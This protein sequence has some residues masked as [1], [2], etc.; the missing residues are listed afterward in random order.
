MKANQKTQRIAG[1]IGFLAQQS[2]WWYWLYAPVIFTLILAMH[3]INSLAK[4][5][6]TINRTKEKKNG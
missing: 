6:L 1:G 2:F 4:E 5:E 3:H